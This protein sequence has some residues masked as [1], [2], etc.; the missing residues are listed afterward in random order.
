MQM[1]S[2]TFI[3]S[4]TVFGGF[5]VELPVSRKSN[6]SQLA[7]ESVGVLRNVLEIY[8]FEELLYKLKGISYHIHDK[9]IQDILSSTDPVYVCNCSSIPLIGTL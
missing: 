7:K 6:I 5:E 1:T 9:T 4:C 8:H 2:R 3:F